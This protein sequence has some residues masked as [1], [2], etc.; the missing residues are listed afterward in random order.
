MPEAFNDEDWKTDD[1][2]WE[3]GDEEDD[4][5]SFAASDGESGDWEDEVEY[6]DEDYDAEGS[7][8]DEE[9]E[10]EF[11]GVNPGY[12][13]QYPAD[14]EQEEE[15][16]GPTRKFY[17]ACCLCLICLLVVG[18]AIALGVVMTA[19]GDAEED[20]LAPTVTRIQTPAPV[21]PTPI[22]V[23]PTYAP[24]VLPPSARPLPTNFPTI[25]PAPTIRP[26]AKPTKVPSR[27]PTINPTISFEPTRAVPDELYL[28]PDADTYIY[29][30]GFTQAEAYGDEETMLVQ[31]GP[32]DVNEVPD[33]YILMTF[34]L[35]LLPGPER[36][37]DRQNRAI[38]RLNHVI[39]SDA[40][41]LS[42]SNYTVVRLPQ[43]PLAVETLH[44]LLFSPYG[45][46]QGPS[47]VVDPFDGRI[48][49]DIT[50]LLFGQPPFAPE[51]RHSRDLQG[52]GTQLFLMIEN[53]GPEQIDGGDRFQTRESDAPP[54]L[55]IE[56]LKTEDGLE[57][58][59]SSPELGLDNSFNHSSSP[60]PSLA[61]SAEVEV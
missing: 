61:P 5:S 56:L 4:S 31:N 28:I 25:S 52:P 22:F 29:A 32:A 33:A 10:K 1:E 16:Q 41:D 2:S 42:P 15:N 38:L 48:E 17:F 19:G 12:R 55:Y 58:A 34:D 14:P 60:G 18:G 36:I 40:D 23:L 35:E 8:V 51:V 30:D 45:G 39:R 44:G 24:G 7:S 46:I 3:S 53:N 13:E 37:A 26:S 54:E 11:E 9:N 21:A 6:F 50:P 59:G 43:T 47:F 20:T 49:V 57:P 27:F